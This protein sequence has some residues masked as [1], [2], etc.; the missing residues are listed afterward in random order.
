MSIVT[1]GLFASER[2]LQS[3][4][5]VYAWLKIG[6]FQSQ[7]EHASCYRNGRVQAVLS[8][9]KAQDFICYQGDCRSGENR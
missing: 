5:S 4:R 9:M 8:R 2:M 6:T 1:A 3:L 7:G